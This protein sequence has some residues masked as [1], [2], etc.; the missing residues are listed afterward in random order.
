M[1]SFLML[2]L[3]CLLSVTSVVEAQV[4]NLGLNNPAVEVVEPKNN[5]IYRGRFLVKINNFNYRPELA[6]NP[7]L[8]FAI[9]QDSKGNPLYQNEGHV[10]GWVFAVDNKGKVIREDTGRPTPQSYLRFYGAG[11]A[12]T[13]GDYNEMYYIKSDDLSDLPAGKYRAF[14]QL[15][16]NDHTASLQATA[17]AFPAIAVVDFIKS[18]K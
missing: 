12:L 3:V 7:V 17:P 6:T 9:G 1:K 5:G 16:Q 10:H 2:V 13:E 15:Q 14:F 11:G 18:A 4:I 8:S